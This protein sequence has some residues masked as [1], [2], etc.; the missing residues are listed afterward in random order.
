MDYEV[1]RVTPNEWWEHRR[2]RL[3]GLKESPAAFSTRYDEAL[4]RPD[5]YWRETTT[6]GADGVAVGSFVAIVSGAF[7]GMATAILDEGVTDTRCYQIVGVYVVPD[8]RGRRLGLSDALVAEVVRWAR[9]DAG[10]E[11]VRLYVTDTNDRAI[12]FYR[13]LGFTETGG[14]MPYPNDPAVQEVEMDFRGRH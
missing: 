5:E 14:S 4:A 9:Q 1:R 2:L 12:S 10:A 3:E 8:F 6:R 11:R 13:R 7:V